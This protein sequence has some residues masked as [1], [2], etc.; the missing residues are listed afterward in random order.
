[1]IYICLERRRRNILYNE[2]PR[3]NKAIN[4]EVYCQQLDR[5]NERLKE[6]C[7]QLPQTEKVRKFHDTTKTK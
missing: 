5:A 6:N 4:F 2:L 7:L 3:P 1:M